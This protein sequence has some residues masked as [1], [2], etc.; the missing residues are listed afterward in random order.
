MQIT[1]GSRSTNL[2]GAYWHG[3]EPT[4][5]EE[6]CEEQAEEREEGS[7]TLQVE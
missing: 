7:E 5:T 4:S 2:L 1:L 3:Q 6:V